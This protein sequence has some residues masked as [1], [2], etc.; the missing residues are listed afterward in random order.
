MYDGGRILVGLAIF[1]AFF[2]FPFW[3]NLGNAAYQGPKL[4][5]P[6]EKNCV[7]TKQFMLEKH[8]QLL[9]EWR[10]EY[11]RK[12]V[13]SYKNQLTGQKFK[14]S[15]T[16]TC[17]KCHQKEKFCDKCHSSFA[18]QPYCWDCHVAPKGAK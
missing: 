16:K 18:V 15:L 5:L 8:M 11:V 13:I 7:N 2:T 6:K 9:N 14:I 4:E 17:L 12:H 1:V 10:D 3:Y